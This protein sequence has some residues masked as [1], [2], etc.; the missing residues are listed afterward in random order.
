MKTLKEKAHI[1][2]GIVSAFSFEYSNAP[3][4]EKIKNQLNEKYYPHN[5]VKEAVLELKKRLKDCYKIESEG[6]CG[7]DYV[8]DN[9]DYYNSDDVDRLVDEIFGDFSEDEK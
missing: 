6:D 3:N 2:H 4:F 8:Y 7:N 9:E 5:D 1:K